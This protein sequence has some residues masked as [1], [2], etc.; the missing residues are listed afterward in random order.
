L[1]E[2]PKSER[3]REWTLNLGRAYLLSDRKDKAKKLL[4]TF[5]LQHPGSAEAEKAK[6]LLN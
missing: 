1:K 4:D 3:S 2:F 5:I 6:A